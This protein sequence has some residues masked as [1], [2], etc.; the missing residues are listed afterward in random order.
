MYRAIIPVLVLSIACGGKSSK[1]DPDAA[2]P[3]DAE[4]DAPVAPVFRNVVNLPDEILAQQALGILTSNCSSCHGM[5]RQNLRYWRG[6][7]DV[8][9]QSCLTDLTVATEDSARSMIECM[10]SM[11][12]LPSSDFSTKKLGVYAV[13]TK[14]PWFEYTFWRAYGSE[15]ATK[16]AELQARAGMPKDG[17]PLSQEQFDI[18]AEWYTRG[19]PMLDQSLPTDPPPNT[20]TPSISA[21]VA[22]HVTAMK[23]QG[24]RAVNKMN[25]MAMHGC[26]TQN[27]LECFATTGAMPGHPDLKLLVEV[28][29][30]SSYW[31][32]S[33]PDGR[34]IGHGVANIP[35]SYILDLQRDAARIAVNAQ[36]DPNW[37]PDSSGFVFQGG[38][39]NVCG[40]SVLTSNPSSVTMTEA[41]CSSITSIGLYEHV[42]RALG[43]G[44]Y[45][46][47]DSGFVS[48]DGG[49]TATLRDPYASFST[50][51][52][53]SFIPMIFDGTKYVSKPQVTIGTPFEGD[54]VISPSAKL[55]ITRVAGQNDKQLGY[56]LRRV[57]ATP[58]GTTYTVAAPEIARYC[59]SGGKPGFS[60]DERWIVFH[61]YVTSA[62]A[63]EL[64]FTGP[65]DP[66]FAPYLTQGA[67]NVYLMD[68]QTGVPTR[69]TNMAPGQYALFPH[70]RSDGW[71]YATIRDRNTDHEYMVASDAAL[72]AE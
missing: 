69:I 46:A 4:I 64:G 53:L 63:V 21:D 29:Y 50:N 30:H 72:K 5:T 65:S 11:P 32:R 36:Y 44:D 45:F 68:L 33:S 22:P 17:T 58:S 13:A 19:L 48:D 57:D 35:G 18:V 25:L 62:D 6:L 7:S 70:F 23:T 54:T 71:I 24:W 14:L 27:P 9:M 8:T 51:A 43:A 66:S 41:A 3:P 60:Y 59:V 10:R 34:F 56:V 1:A 40:E 39:G 52:H 20:C 38:P 16:L 42:G 2:Q 15:G 31:S 28:E 47:V 12:Q 55:V 67:A 37:F 26:A 61:H 49:H